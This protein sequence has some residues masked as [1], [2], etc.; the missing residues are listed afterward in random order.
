MPELDTWSVRPVLHVRAKDQK[1]AEQYV[2]DAIENWDD[3]VKLQHFNPTFMKRRP[4]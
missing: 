3:A 4:E 2:A 1:E